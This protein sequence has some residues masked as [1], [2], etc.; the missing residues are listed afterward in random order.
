MKNLVKIA[1][2]LSLISSLSLIGMGA[3]TAS[4]GAGTAASTAASSIRSAGA[5]VG[6]HARDLQRSHREYNE[7]YRNRNRTPEQQAR[8]E[9]MSTQRTDLKD[10]IRQGGIRNINRAL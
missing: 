3:T 8:F 9:E 6:A 4:T 1:A 2:V 10:A 7:L 5:G